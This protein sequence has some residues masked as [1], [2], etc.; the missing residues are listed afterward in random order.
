MRLCNPHT[1]HS[2]APEP[3][4][5]SQAPLSVAPLAQAPLAQAQVS[6]AQLSHRASS[7]GGQPGADFLTAEFVSG[8]RWREGVLRTDES[9]DIARMWTSAEH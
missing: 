9:W 4:S 2:S 1:P 8:L 7:I 3:C 6:V 5:G